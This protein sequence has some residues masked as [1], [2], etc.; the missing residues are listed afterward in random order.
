[1]G[2]HPMPKFRAALGASMRLAGG[3][4]QSLSTRV[5]SFSSFSQATMVLASGS[6]VSAKLCPLGLGPCGFGSDTNWM[7]G[8]NDPC[9]VAAANS[10][11]GS[12]DW[13]IG[14]TSSRTMRMGRGMRLIQEGLSAVLDS[15]AR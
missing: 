3:L 7:C 4:L 9:A 5:Y 6:W 1:M 11:V 10:I 8:T 12:K 14:Y 13:M 2:L 15:S